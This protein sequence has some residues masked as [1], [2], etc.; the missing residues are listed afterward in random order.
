MLRIFYSPRMV[1]D[2]ESFSPSAGKPQAVVGSWRAL[3]LPIEIVAAYPVSAALFASAHDTEFISDV[4]AGRRNNEFGNRSHAVAAS[5]PYTSGSMLSAARAALGYGIAISPSAGFHHA[6]Y[7]YAGGF[8]TFNGLMVAACILHREGRV[9]RVGILDFDTHYGDGTDDIIETLGIG[10]IE[11]FTAGADYHRPSQ[12]EE[13]L[14]ALP[15]IVQSMKRCDLILYQAGADPHVD[16][17]L[18]GWLTTKQLA[19]R[20]LIVFE[21]TKALGLPIAWNLAGGYQEPLRN[22]LDIHDNTLMAC[23]QVYGA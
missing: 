20:D 7:D 14:R 18:G 6:G 4:L 1:A 10:W 3:G 23:W 12:A 2:S 17:P 22:V 5:L 9:R 19:E 13:F 21:T 15:G 11:H 8:C 16:D